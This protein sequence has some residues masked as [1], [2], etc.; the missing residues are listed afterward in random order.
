MRHFNIY[1]LEISLDA[2]GSLFRFVGCGNGEVDAVSLAEIIKP[3]K[4]ISN[5]LG[6]GVIKKLVEIVYENVSDII[7]ACVQTTDKSTKKIVC[8][9]AVLTGVNKT[10]GVGYIISEVLVLLDANDV[11]VFLSNSPYDQI[12][13]SFGFAGALQ[14]HNKLNHFNHAPFVIICAGL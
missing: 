6:G 11:A 14:T 5:R 8:V 2:V 10:C 4:H 1:D 7:V 9:D 13:K 3:I 12:N